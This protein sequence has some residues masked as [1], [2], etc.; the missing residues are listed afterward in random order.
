MEARNC[1]D[2]VVTQ[3]TTNTVCPEGRACHRRPLCPGLPG[4]ARSLGAE[5]PTLASLGMLRNQP[6]PVRLHALCRILKLNF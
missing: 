6:N 2:S 3:F 5:E 4:F 1:A